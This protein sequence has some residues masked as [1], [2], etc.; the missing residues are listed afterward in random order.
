MNNKSPNDGTSKTDEFFIELIAKQ[1]KLLSYSAG[2]HFWHSALSISDGLLIHLERIF[3]IFISFLLLSRL[4]H[5]FPSLRCLLRSSSDICVFLV[6]QN[7][8][9]KKKRPGAHVC[10]LLRHCCVSASPTILEDIERRLSIVKVLA[11][12]APAQLSSKFCS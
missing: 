3:F 9:K 10:F 1:P 4:F 6:I 7:K 5:S 2:F 11:T 12:W 8:E